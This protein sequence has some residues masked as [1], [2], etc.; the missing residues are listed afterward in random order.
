MVEVYRYKLASSAPPVASF[1]YSI[2]DE[3]SGLVSFY[4]TSFN[5][6][7]I[8]WFFGD[9]QT[10]IEENIHQYISDGTYEVKLVVNNLIGTDTVSQTLNI[11]VLDLPIAVGNQSCTPTSLNYALKVLILIQILIGMIALLMEI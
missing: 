3:C 8:E 9:N 1:D 5:S 6:E 2:N 11:D 7:T 10:S 4:N